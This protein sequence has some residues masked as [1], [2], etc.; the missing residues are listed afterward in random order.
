MK[1]SSLVF[2]LDWCPVCS[3][4]TCGLGENNCLFILPQVPRRHGISRRTL[5]MAFT[6]KVCPSCCWLSAVCKRLQVLLPPWL[7]HPPSP[8]WGR[9]LIF[10]FQAWASPHFYPS[11]LSVPLSSH[12][13]W[14]SSP[15]VWYLS[16][17]SVSC[18]A[19]PVC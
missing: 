17:F 6:Y 13:R 14:I 9:R 1:H 18:S 12:L 2:L 4:R 10:I 16:C 19:L 8:A 7:Q 3:V 5:L 15:V 11:L